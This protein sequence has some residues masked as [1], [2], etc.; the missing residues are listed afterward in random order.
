MIV[1]TKGLPHKTFYANQKCLVFFMSIFF[2][3]YLCVS[4]CLFICLG[5]AGFYTGLFLRCDYANDDIWKNLLTIVILSLLSSIQLEERHRRKK[6]ITVRKVTFLPVYLFFL[7]H[8]FISSHFNSSYEN[9]ISQHFGQF[10]F[11]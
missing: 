4:S 7:S 10:F 1:R 3:C 11:Q 9:A 6:T 8:F 2:L 5:Y